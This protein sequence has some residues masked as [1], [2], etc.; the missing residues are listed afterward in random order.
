M[1]VL[2]GSGS[3][4]NYMVGRMKTALGGRTAMHKGRCRLVQMRRDIPN[5]D[6]S[7]PQY[8]QFV[9]IR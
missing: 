8:S 5:Q 3:S 7:G 9:A 6:E 2:L 1:E 4:G